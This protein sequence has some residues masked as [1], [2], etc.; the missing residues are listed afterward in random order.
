MAEVIDARPAGFGGKPGKLVI[1]ARYVDYAG[2]RIILHAMMLGGSGQNNGTAS[3]AMGLATG[4]LPG[5]IVQGGDLAYPAGT[6]TSAKV[7]ADVTLPP[8]APPPTSQGPAT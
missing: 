7:G 8:P 3:L 5:M 6:T 4:F 2:H 1:A